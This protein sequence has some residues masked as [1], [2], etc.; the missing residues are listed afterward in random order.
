MSRTQSTQDAGLA[1]LEALFTA[2]TQ[3]SAR[4][5]RKAGGMERVLHV[6]CLALVGL[7]AGACGGADSVSGDEHDGA[8]GVFVVV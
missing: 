7:L 5:G 3:N 8:G 2:P 6:V 4:M 1:D